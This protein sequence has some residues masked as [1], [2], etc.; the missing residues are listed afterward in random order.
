MSRQTASTARTTDHHR[1]SLTNR[2]SCAD[3][4]AEFNQLDL[5]APSTAD[6]LLNKIKERFVLIPFFMSSE[7]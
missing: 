5:I 4:L 7:M 1:L 6:D 3:E 2:N